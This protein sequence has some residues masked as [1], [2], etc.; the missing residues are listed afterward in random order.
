MSSVPRQLGQGIEMHHTYFQAH[1]SVLVLVVTERCATCDMDAKAS[2]RKPYVV[3]RERSENVESLD[4]V[5][6]SA[7][8]GRS[9]FFNVE[10]SKKKLGQT[11]TKVLRGYRIHYLVSAAASNHRLSP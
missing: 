1:V 6:R 4:V 8:I 9:A 3:R 7:R 10:L 5:K 2:P 11:E